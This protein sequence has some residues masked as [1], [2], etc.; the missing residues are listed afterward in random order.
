MSEDLKPTRLSL[1]LAENLK[2]RKVRFVSF[3][4]NVHLDRG[5]AARTDLDLL[6]HKDD[7]NDFQVEILSLGFLMMIPPVWS[8]YPGIEDWIGF[9]PE[10]GRLHHLHVHYILLTGRKTVKH[11]NIPWE[12]MI[13]QHVIVDPISQ[14]PVPVPEVELAVMLVRLWAKESLTG[15]MRFIITRRFMLPKDMG[16]ELRYLLQKSDISLLVSILRKETACDLGQDDVALLDRIKKD[17]DYPAIGT[18]S[19]SLNRQL[20]NHWRAGTISVF[21]TGMKN[22]TKLTIVHICTKL[23]IPVHRQKMLSRGGRMISFIGVDG[24]GK[25]TLSMDIASWLQYKVDAHLFYLG[26]GTG[27]PK[28]ERMALHLYESFTGIFIKIIPKKCSINSFFR[29]S[30]KLSF[31]FI[32]RRNF[33]LLRKARRLCIDGSV[34][35][36]DRFPQ[37]QQ[38]GINDG[39]KLQ[40]GECFLWAARKEMDFLRQSVDLGPDMVIRLNVSAEVAIQRKPET[41][42]VTLDE[43]LRSIREITFERADVVE[44]DANCPY[45]QVLTGVKKEIWRDL[46][47]RF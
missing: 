33:H 7:V 32:A 20:G 34:T 4:S 26:S 1:Q 13:F 23:G 36:T 31:L 28:I 35:I 40:N 11:L 38:R 21:I 44:V 9:D 37:L 43:K 16:D 18:I 19:R 30:Q 14:W 3:K 6:I 24:S 22:R 2:N 42:L 10:S 15:R 45:P 39:P 17:Q 27:M 29:K 47:G 25:S 41:P 46:V 5:L 8:S 12:D